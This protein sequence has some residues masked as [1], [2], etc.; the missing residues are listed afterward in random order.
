M[1]RVSSSSR[2]D[3]LTRRFVDHAEATRELSKLD[4][5][6]PA[7][8]RHVKKMMAV[9]DALTALP[10]GRVRLEKLMTDRKPFVRLRAAQ[11]VRRWA[12]H[13]A[14]PVLGRLIAD[15]FKAELSPGERLELRISA[16]DSLCIHFDIMSFDQNDL[17]EPLAAYGIDLP[18]QDHSVWQ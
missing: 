2:L 6:V 8:N 7:F 12:P 3:D 1:I 13:L 14:I 16:K 11:E 18:W 15:D 17:I 9:G 4:N 5:D 10:E